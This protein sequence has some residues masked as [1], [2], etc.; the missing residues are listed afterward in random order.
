MT[1]IVPCKYTNISCGPH[2]F[3]WGVVNNPR[4]YL[5]YLLI[6]LFTSIYLVDGEDLEARCR[7]VRTITPPLHIPHPTLATYYVGFIGGGLY[8]GDVIYPLRLLL[9]VVVVV[10]VFLGG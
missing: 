10:V 9:I 2:A 3:P 7:G 1:P 8:L 4:I 5:W 6:K